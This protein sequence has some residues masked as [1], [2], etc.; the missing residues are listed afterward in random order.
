MVIAFFQIARL[1]VQEMPNKSGEIKFDQYLAYRDIQHYLNVLQSK[2]KDTVEVKN[3]GLSVENRHLT[4]IKIGN[5]TR[6]NGPLIFIDAGIHAREWISSAQALYTI[7]QLVENRNN[8]A[9]IKDVDWV[10]VPLVNP[11]G[12]EYSRR[13][14]RF[15]RKNRAKGRI[16]YGVDLNRNFDFHWL[17]RGASDGECSN[18]FAGMRPFSEPES[19]ALSRLIR[20]NSK[21]IKIYISFHAAAQSI[22]YPWGYTKDLPENGK[23]LHKLAT[24]V[25]D[26]V[27]KVNFTQYRI[28]SA[29]NLLYIG[30]GSSFD[31]T[32]AVAKVKLCYTIELKGV[33]GARFKHRF[34]IAAE[35]ILEVVSEM[36]E[37]LK[38]IHLYVERNFS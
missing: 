1:R 19:S 26:A 27:H 24:K 28:G 15:W 36:F 14:D 11:D 35:D 8:A 32:Y 23:E 29:A 31:W 38:E 2:Y 21:R 34:E 22:L 12:Y 18:F 17:G 33:S 25:S 7:S 37:G 5:K 10:I 3:F 30:S 4:Y 13:V 6:G 9:M 16:C 20:E